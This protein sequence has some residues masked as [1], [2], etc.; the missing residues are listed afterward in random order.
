[1][2]LCKKPRRLMYYAV[3]IAIGLLLIGEGPAAQTA[4]ANQGVFGAWGDTYPESDSSSARCQ[5]C[6]IN[7]GGGNPWNAYGWEIRQHIRNGGMSTEDAIK[8]AETAD[9]DKDGQSN[10][11]EIMFNVQPGW[12]VEGNLSYDRDGITQTVESSAAPN[13]RLDL[14]LENP[15]TETITS[16]GAISIELTTVITDL[17]SPVMGTA[18]ASLPDYL[19]IVEQ[20]GQVWQTNAASGFQRLF[21]DLSSSLVPLGVAGSGT[22]DERGLL[23]FI[24]HPQYAENGLVYTYASEPISGTADFTTIPMTAT[25]TANHQAVIAQWTVENPTHPVNSMV[26][27]STKKVLLRID[28]PQF[29]HNGG[30]LAFG[31]DNML[32][33]ALGDGGGRDDEGFGHGATGNGLDA[34]NPLGTILRIDPLGNSSANGMYGIPADNP[35]VGATDGTLTEIYAYGFRNPYRISFDSQTGALY[36]ADVGQGHIEEIDIVEAGGNYGWKHLEGSFFFDDNGAQRGF[37][38]D[39]NINAIPQT[40]L[41]GLRGPIAEYD[42]DE[43]ISVTG[44]F[45]YRGAALPE[46][47]GRYIFGDWSRSFGA[48]E[49]RLFYL[50][51]ANAIREFQLRNRPAV[52][53]YVS[54][55]AQDASGELYVMGNTTGNPFPAEGV[56]TGVV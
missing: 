2:L 18:T 49:G 25:E 19:F 27:T 55:F 7:A 14:A 53:I 31:P 30:A 21:F 48:P 47:D 13:V 44:G 45:V 42:H 51:A 24:F 50:D 15:I 16:T 22:F 9:S 36:A 10:L 17:V 35:F 26:M 28:Q 52:E 12:S 6:H 20:T 32:Y 8:A 41:D 29:N 4:S 5:L 23:S 11:V 33:I 54:G 56:N 34:T 37:A 46:L 1:M 39:L 40:V 3:A 43:G 38:T